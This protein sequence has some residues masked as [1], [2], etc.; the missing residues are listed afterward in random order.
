MSMSDQLGFRS[1]RSSGSVDNAMAEI[2]Q[3]DNA[4]DSVSDEAMRWAAGFDGLSRLE[5]RELEHWLQASDLNLAAFKKARKTWRKFGCLTQLQNHPAMQRELEL[6]KSRARRRRIKRNGG[7]MAASVA[8]VALVSALLNNVPRDYSAEYRTA[9]GEQLTVGLPDD[10]IVLLNTDTRLSVHYSGNVRS[11][12]LERGE[13]HF[14]VL[15][16]PSRPFAV[17]VGS[18]IV[19]VVGTAFN[20]QLLDAQQLEITVTQGEVEILRGLQ[21]QGAAAPVVDLLEKRTKPVQRL[22]RG[23]NAKIS[24]SIDAV[25]IVDPQAMARK[26]AWQEGWLRFVNVPLGDVIAEADRYTHKSLVVTDSELARRLVTISGKAMD[27]DELLEVLAATS[28]DFVVNTASNGRVE[29]SP[30]RSL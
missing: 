7:L 19:R 28:D 21:D 22:T 11:V 27:I 18:R 30:A 12:V 14:E 3:S 26:L 24:G 29:I 23:H 4:A 13:A 15:H 10:S 2:G 1:T 17:L 20:V 6:L 9:V 5:R 25:D 16:D 8:L